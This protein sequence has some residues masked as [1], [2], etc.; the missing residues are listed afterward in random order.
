MVRNDEYKVK[1]KSD[2]LCVREEANNLS[3]IVTIV[4]Q[5]GVYTIDKEINGWGK[6]K[7]NAGWIQLIYTE[8]I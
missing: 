7:S 6:L 5:G 3:D 2:I 4:Y 8:K 1:I